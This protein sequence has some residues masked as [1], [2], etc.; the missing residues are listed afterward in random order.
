MFPYE[1]ATEL[2]KALKEAG[3][4]LGYISSNDLSDEEFAKEWIALS[5]EA[6]N[7]INAKAN[8]N[9]D[10]S[11]YQVTLSFEDIKDLEAREINA[12]NV[13]KNLGI[14]KGYDDGTY[15]PNNNITRAEV[16]IIL[17]RFLEIIK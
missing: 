3:V 14:V 11:N 10:F 4:E 13:M 15:K 2:K 6:R 1:Q 8:Q 16:S 5:E 12:V 7:E 17:N 9:I